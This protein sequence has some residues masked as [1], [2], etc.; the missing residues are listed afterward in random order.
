[1]YRSE[2]GGG[3]P[4][5][6]VVARVHRPLR[7]DWASLLNERFFV[8]K[9]FLAGFLGRT[10]NADSSKPGGTLARYYGPS[11]RRLSRM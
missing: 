3:V 2:S 11:D 7:M 10:T 4:A 5:A 6:G 8:I 9:S 1:M